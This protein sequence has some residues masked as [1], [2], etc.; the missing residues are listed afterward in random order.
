MATW[1]AVSLI[2]VYQHVFLCQNVYDKAT[3]TIRRQ[4]TK[5]K[6]RSQN[7][8][9]DSDPYTPDEV[10]PSEYNR[11]SGNSIRSTKPRVTRGR[12]RYNRIRFNY[13]DPE[14]DYIRISDI[15]GSDK[16]SAQGIASQ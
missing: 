13:F 10:D 5:T 9:G 14:T 3:R 2:T 6:T 4:R 15:T 16:K 8:T 12:P 11:G 7:Q 1:T